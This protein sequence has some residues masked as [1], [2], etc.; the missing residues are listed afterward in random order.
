MHTTLTTEIRSDIPQVRAQGLFFIA[1]PHVAALP[2]MQRLEGYREQ[3][4]AKVLFCLEKSRELDLVPVFLGDMFHWPRENPNGLLVDL[5]EMFRPYMPWVLVGNHD[6]YQARLT[7]DVSLAVLQAAGVIHLIDHG[8]PVFRLATPT[9]SV[10]LGASPDGYPLPGSFSS[11]GDDTVIWISHHNVGF[12][13]FR[14]KPVVIR[15]IPG[16]DLVVNGHI[17]RPQPSE[18]KGQTLWTNPG[19]ITRLTFSRRTKERQPAAALWRPGMKDLE[20]LAIPFLPFEQVFPDQEFPVEEEQGD[21]ESGFLNGLERL[22]WRRTQEGLG[23]KEFLEAN[24]N[25][26]QPETRLVWD[27]YKEIID[28]AANG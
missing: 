27:L 21:V 9:H 25:P 19:N 12:P 6:K 23:L 14:D 17:H 10:L 15:E 11:P 3:V 22:S 28:G 24:L 8:G 20:P 1:D 18:Q 7:P 2:P 5:I 16:V 26:E 4:L 13:D